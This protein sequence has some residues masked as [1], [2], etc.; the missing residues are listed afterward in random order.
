MSDI[1]YHLSPCRSGNANL[2]LS[3]IGSLALSPSPQCLSLC[4]SVV[5]LCKLA[6]VYRVMESIQ[7]MS[8]FLSLLLVLCADVFIEPR[9]PG[10]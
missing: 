6:T 7:K 10:S 4:V 9:F 1:R 8:L 5:P 2:S 3:L